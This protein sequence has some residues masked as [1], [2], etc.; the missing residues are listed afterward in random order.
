MAVVA[1]TPV[2]RSSGTGTAIHHSRSRLITVCGRDGKDMRVSRTE[3]GAAIATT[4]GV[5]VSTSVRI[6]PKTTAPMLAVCHHGRPTPRRLSMC[7]LTTTA[8][9]AAAI[10]STANGVGKIRTYCSIASTPSCR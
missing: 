7:T 6:T 3:A 9:I 10:A 5:R 4:G 2:R 1:R 8:T